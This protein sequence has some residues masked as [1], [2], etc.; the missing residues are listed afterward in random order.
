MNNKIKKISFPFLTSFLKKRVIFLLLITLSSFFFQCQRG[1]NHKSQQYYIEVADAYNRKVIIESEP[2]RI[3]SLSPA[4]TE[5][6]YLLKKEEKLIGISNFCNYPPETENIEKIGGLIQLNLEKITSLQPDLILIGSIIR[7]EEVEKMEQL[8]IPVIAIREE[9]KIDGL[10]NSLQ[11]LGNILDCRSLA[12][13]LNGEFSER[14]SKL[15]EQKMIENRKKR[16]WYVVGFGIAGDF[17]APKES[18][19]HE[20]ITLAGGKNVGESLSGWRISREL[21]FDINPDYIFIR[22]EDYEHFIRSFPYSQLQA[23]KRGNVFE[24]ESGWIDIV[25]PRNFDAI[26]FIH[27]CI[28]EN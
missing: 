15:S 24:I 21:I 26:E 4:I 16:V 20:I 5:I 12:E 13:K 7:K 11:L 9:K 22:K 2:Q 28:E 18:H 19:I 1:E 14:L 27:R 8:G 23:V 6:I 25:S 3:I 10:F 17:A